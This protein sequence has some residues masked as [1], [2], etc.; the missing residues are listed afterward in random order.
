[1]AVGTEDGCVNIMPYTF[2]ATVWDF[3][4][5]HRSGITHLRFS[6]ETNLIFS[7][8]A[9]GNLF[10]YCI[11]EIQ[12]EN[13]G[14]RENQKQSFNQ[15]SSVLDEGLGENVLYPLERIFYS[16]E[17]LKELKYKV[18][19]NNKNEEHLIKENQKKMKERET[20]LMKKKEIEIS[21]LNDII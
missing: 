5:S 13:I 7:A 12:E 10:I 17:E 14:V 9:D 21:Q 19:E 16:E 3:L 4:K 6:R 8:G 18:A 15:L 2:D 20:E 1:M 11:H